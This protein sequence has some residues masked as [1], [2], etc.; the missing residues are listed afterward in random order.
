MTT[1]LLKTA[2]F[3][4]L[5][6]SNQIREDLE[7]FVSEI[8]ELY[9]KDLLS[10][11]VFGSSVSGGYIEEESDL[12]LL[13]VYSELDIDDLKKVSHLASKWFK[14]R[15]FTP[16]F[17][18]KRNLIDSV[19]YFQIDWMDIRDTNVVLYGEDVLKQLGVYPVDMRWQ[20]AHEI[21][22]MR[23]RIKQQFWRA[24]GNEALMKKILTQRVSSLIHLMRTFLFLKTRRKPPISANEIL[25]EAARELGIDKQFVQSILLLKASKKPLKNEELL[26]GFEKLLELIRTIDQATDSLAVS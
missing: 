13:V 6:V 18:S 24:F 22:R 12:N 1:N 2:E 3:E 15:K 20:L 10:I 19:K 11:S 9:Q 4:R 5:N 25:E 8:V 16:R 26:E 21:K 14:K 23:M 17:L 7:K